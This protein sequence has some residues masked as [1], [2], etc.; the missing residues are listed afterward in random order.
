MSCE[1]DKVGSDWNQLGP[2]PGESQWVTLN[3][4]CDDAEAGHE[5]VDH[6]PARGHVNNAVRQ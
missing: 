2:P 6:R 4:A 3:L 5:D 1:V